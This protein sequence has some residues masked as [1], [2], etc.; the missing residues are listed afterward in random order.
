VKSQRPYKN[1]HSGGI[2]MIQNIRP[3]NEKGF[4]LIELMIVIAIIGILAA[5][6]IPQF[7]TYRVRANNTSSI[8]LL[9]VTVSSEAALNSDLGCWGISDSTQSLTNAAGGSGAGAILDGQ[10]TAA[11]ADMGGAHLTATNDSNSVS[12]VGFT[13]ADGMSMRASTTAN[14]A[15][16]N[17]FSYQIISTSEGGNRVFGADSEVSDVIYYV[18]NETW[19][20]EDLAGAVT[21]GLNIPTLDATSMDFAVAGATGVTGG[22]APTDAW[23]LLQ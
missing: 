3:N 21:N 11:T 5:I 22:G 19:V 9:K 20:G 12:A 4:T 16:A 8:A 7:S 17:N 14:A 13:V 15:T 10:I 6:A 2:K 23:A 18:Q 1:N